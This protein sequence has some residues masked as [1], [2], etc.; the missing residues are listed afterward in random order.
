M[1][2]LLPLIIKKR[3][4]IKLSEIEIELFIESITS[5]NPPPDY[6]IASLLA[7]IVA[8]GMD[9]EE[10]FWL[11]NAMLK[12]GDA[13]EYK[14]FSPEALFVDK[15]S[16]GGIGDKI[17][18]PLAP[19]VVAAAENLHIPTIAGRALGHTGGTVDKLESIPGFQ[20][21][22]TMDRFYKILK[23]HRLAFLSQ[24]PQI[25][26]ADRI[27]YALR[28]VT[29][30]VS[31]IPLITASILSKKLSESL[32]FLLIDLK[33]GSG[34]FLPD[35]EQTEALGQRMLKVLNQFQK[36]AKICMTNMDTPL[37]HYSGN[38]WEVHESLEILKGQG[39]SSSTRLTLEFAKR[40]LESSGVESSRATQSLENALHSGAALKKFEDSVEAQ[41]GE[42]SKMEKAI[43]DLQ[44][45][46]S[47]SVKA[48]CEGFLKWNVTE[49]GF[50]LVELG[51]GRKTKTDKVDNEV[52]AYHPVD[53]GDR[54]LKNQEILRLYYRDKGRLNVC[55]ERLKSAI[56]IK[57]QAVTKTPLIIKEWAT[58]L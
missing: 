2:D 57:E 20:T 14:G 41:G 17:T 47:F 56:Q 19:L 21:G 54:V 11:T 23:K 37:G 26:P 52:G 10:N 35:R 44:K 6:Q 31:S 51:A 3:D 33:C 15:H 49:L 18:L 5:K 22:L 50:A 38:L 58:T 45:L 9:S 46:K 53:T 24:T 43:A 16:T 7:F 8:R 4:Q 40:I 48:E 29:G 39:P 13:F 27:L 36:R 30:T 55:L 25:A 32:D 1:A 34:A 28:D 42:I 12:S